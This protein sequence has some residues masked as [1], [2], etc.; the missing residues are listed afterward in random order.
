M[1]FCIKRRTQVKQRNLVRSVPENGHG[2][3]TGIDLIKF[4]L[5]FFVVGIHIAPFSAGAFSGA[6]RANFWLQ[7]YLFRLAVPFYFTASG[8]LLFR[9]LDP[10]RLDPEVVQN[11]CLRLLRQLGLW[12]MLLVLGPKGHLWYLKAAVTA[13]VCVSLGVYRK[14][15][16]GVLAALALGLYAV[17]LL[18]DSY[19]G[20]LDAVPA[21]TLADR[22]IREYELVFQTTRNGLFMGVPF[23]LMGAYFAWQRPRLD[24]KWSLAGFAGSMVLMAW[25]V[26]ALDARGLCRN[27][28]LFV[29]LLPAAFFLF[30][31]ALELRVPWVPGRTLR[32]M[33][34]VIYYAHILCWSV[35]QRAFGAENPLLEPVMFPAAALTTA[36]LAWTVVALSQRKGLRWLRWLYQ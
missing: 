2:Q 12:T 13:L 33:G 6:E 1:F 16:P 21:G 32:A 30:A 14:L 9:K 29:F 34:V 28:N 26:S 23:V 10:A 35:L 24:P 18:G 8:F 7:N 11:Q 17:G 27:Y 22:V 4:I 36:A 19:R 15:R 3:L 25:E 20:L 31:L 5:S